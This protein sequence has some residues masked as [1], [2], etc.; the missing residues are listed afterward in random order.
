[1]KNKIKILYTL[2]ILLAVFLVFAGCVTDPCTCGQGTCHG[3]DHDS[4]CNCNPDNGGC[5]CPPDKGGCNCEE[6]SGGCNC[7]PDENDKY[8]PSKYVFL[9][10]GDGMGGNQARAPELYGNTVDFIRSPAK[11]LIYTHD[12][13]YNVTDSAAAGTALASGRKT[14]YGSLNINSDVD[15]TEHFKTIAEYAHEAGIKV[16]VLTTVSLT[17]ATPSAFYGKSS[18]RWDEEELA[19]Q[20]I[21]SGFDYFA[22]GSIVVSDFQNDFLIDAAKGAGYYV[23]RSRGD[24]EALSPV[25]G[26]VIAFPPSEKIQN[27]GSLFYEVDRDY[28]DV[29]HWTLSDITRKGID[30]LHNPDGFFMMI[31]CGKIDWACHNND[32]E[33]AVGEVLSLDQAVKVALDFAAE[34]PD[35]TLIVIT[36]D[37]ETGGMDIASGYIRFTS[38]DHTGVPVPV[39]AFGANSSFFNG[40]FDNTDIFYRIARAMKLKVKSQHSFY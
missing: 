34:Y 35:D 19:V 24:F 31:E 29:D 12:Y 5:N 37:H 38:Y 10:I 25:S 17:H 28:G 26:K 6:G 1:M 22:G 27:D 4:G 15:P 8:R 20:L 36:A 18:N 32:A 9:F 2:M 39:Y 30:V 3:C 7:E 33:R 13:N 11:G 40:N 23:A 14:T 21:A 16:G